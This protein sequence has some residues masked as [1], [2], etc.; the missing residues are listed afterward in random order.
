M[1]KT[2]VFL[3]LG[4]NL[5]ERGRNLQRAIEEMSQEEM[6]SINLSSIFKSEPWGFESKNFFL[7][8]CISFYTTLDAEELLLRLKLIETE[9][10][11]KIHVNSGYQDRIIDIDILFFGDEIINEEQLI[12]PHPRMTERRFTLM[13]MND[14][15]SEFIHPVFGKSIKDLLFECQDTSTVTKL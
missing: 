4:T 3:L 14:L 2:L 5:G 9:L 1:K 12:V 15:S 10:G 6:S 13:A 11:R 7:N 8:Q